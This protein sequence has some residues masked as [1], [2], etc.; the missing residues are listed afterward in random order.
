MDIA[1]NEQNPRCFAV[2]S[3]AWAC[4]EQNMAFQ[5]IAAPVGQ[6]T[7]EV[8]PADNGRPDRFLL[9]DTI[10]RA[11]S[12]LGLKAPVIATLDA[13][14]SCLPP[15][16]NHNV[17]FASNA[18]LTFKRNGIS[19]RTLRRHIEQL[20]DA[21]FLHRSDSPNGKR[22]SKSDSSSGAVLRF[23]I[24][25]GPLFD[26]Y[27]KLCDLADECS[28]QASHISFLR[29]KLRTAIARTLDQTGPTSMLE[30]AQRALRRKL[31]ANEIVAMMDSLVAVEEYTPIEQCEKETPPSKMTVTGGQIDRHL[32][33][34]KKE[35]LDSDG[36]VAAS[37]T[38]SA[39]KQLSLGSLVQACP[40]AMSY[41]QQ[42]PTGA[43][44]V[45]NHAKTLAPM[46][47]IDRA[48][49]LVAEKKLG[50]LGTAVTVWGLLEMQ[51]KI[52][53]L[54]AYFRAVTTGKRSDDFDP[55]ALIRRLSR[56]RPEV[57]C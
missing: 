35:P 46:M 21:G 29:A 39:H 52:R 24:D 49:Y 26:S 57:S 38:V 1:E 22:F 8:L 13:L 14:L 4:C 30:Y 9:I 56:S 45:I 3:S 28:E 33:N 17:V 53:Q 7:L 51:S 54:G 47:G 37:N 32:Q 25:L 18:T 6:R 40:E 19:D 15:R 44:D 48:T 27:T 10:R 11:S 2:A 5:H 42:A 12:A 55:W 43:T 41:I 34:S 31:T 36:E 50:E 16:R 23:G 20:S